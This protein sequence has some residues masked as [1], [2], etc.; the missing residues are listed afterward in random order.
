MRWDASRCLLILRINPVTNNNN[1]PAAGGLQGA[2]AGIFRRIRSITPPLIAG[3]SHVSTNASSPSPRFGPLRG[4]G[5][6]EGQG[7]SA[8]RSL[9]KKGPDSRNR[10]PGGVLLKLDIPLAHDLGP[11]HELA[12]D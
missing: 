6:G 2:A 1:T 4:E 10:P 12:V 11:L 7:L 5:R 9:C 3:L 8:R